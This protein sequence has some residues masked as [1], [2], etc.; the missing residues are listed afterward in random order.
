MPGLIISKKAGAVALSE[1]FT[2]IKH[3]K[4]SCRLEKD[5]RTL[6]IR[7]RADSGVF[8]H[9]VYSIG[10]RKVAVQA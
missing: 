2:A 10:I 8:R 9:G 4:G 6:F 1:C 7:G 5:S 3:K